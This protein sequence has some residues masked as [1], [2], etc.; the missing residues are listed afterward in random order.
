MSKVLMIGYGNRLRGD[1]GLGPRAVERLHETHPQNEAIVCQQ[2]TPELAEAVSGCRLALF[3]DASHEGTPGEARKEAL[4]PAAGDASSFTHDL[5]P[6]VLLALSEELYGEAPEAILVT[7][8]GARFEGEGM[9]AAGEAA[10][11]AACGIAE[12]VLREFGAVG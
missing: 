8:T 10:L 11:L 4:L 7:G 5:Q 12:G 2:L 3:V 1:D 9:S 6:S